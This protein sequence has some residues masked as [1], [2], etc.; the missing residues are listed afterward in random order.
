MG[1]NRAPRRAVGKS[2]LRLRHGG[3]SSPSPSGHEVFGKADVST[4]QRTNL[5]QS[6]ITV[7]LNYR[8]HM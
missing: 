8:R 2:T 1:V 5:R 3:V 4:A 7:W 6:S